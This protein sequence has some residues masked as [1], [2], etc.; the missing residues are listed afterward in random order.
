MSNSLQF[1]DIDVIN[2][3]IPVHQARWA[4]PKVKILGMY[5]V[6]H[7]YRVASHT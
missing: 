6:V 2:M 5:S 1:V 7:H 4:E 3:S